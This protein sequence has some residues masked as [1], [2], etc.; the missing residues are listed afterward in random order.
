[1]K[2]ATLAAILTWTTLAGAAQ[3]AVWERETP[4]ESRLPAAAPYHFSEAERAWFLERHS[5]WPEL[6]A[7]LRDPA[8][9]PWGIILSDFGREFLVFADARSALHVVEV[10][11]QPVAEAVVKPPYESPRFEVVGL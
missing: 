10:T 7:Y 6:D 9:T 2:L 11:G 4:P 3:A 1:M 8:G 5:H